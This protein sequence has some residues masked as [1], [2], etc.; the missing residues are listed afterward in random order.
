VGSNPAATLVLI[1]LLTVFR[2]GGQQLKGAIM[3]KKFGNSKTKTCGAKRLM[4]I[5]ASITAHFFETVWA[6]GAS[7]AAAMAIS[8]PI[9]C[10]GRSEASRALIG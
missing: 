3:N 5:L 6:M 9:Y 1:A 4:S 7:V 2:F 10:A 8:T